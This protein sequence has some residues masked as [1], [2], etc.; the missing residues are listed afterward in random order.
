MWKEIDLSRASEKELRRAKQEVSV[1]S[2]MNHPNI[3]TFYND[4]VDGRTLLIE[5]E[6]ANGK[7]D[8]LIEHNGRTKCNL[9]L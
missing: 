9:L 3:I 8:S 7:C 4:Y 1:L 2:L 6:Y 5:M